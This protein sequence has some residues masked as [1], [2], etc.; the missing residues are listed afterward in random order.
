[1]LQPV[2]KL[3]I[4]RCSF[5]VQTS[6]ADA[7]TTLIADVVAGIEASTQLQ[8]IAPKGSG[9]TVKLEDIDLGNQRYRWRSN[10]LEIAGR[11]PAPERYLGPAS[12]E[13]P[14]QEQRHFRVLLAEI[15]ADAVCSRKIERRE[16]RGEYDE[17]PRDSSFFYAELSNLMTEF[18]PVAHRLVVPEGGP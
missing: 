17:E 4:A 10:V 1:V 15:V 3:G 18:A 6:K 16:A 5:A 7:A 9:I 14:G 11:H 12:Q 2:A 13:F 8:G